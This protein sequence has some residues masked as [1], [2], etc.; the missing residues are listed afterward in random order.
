MSY[1]FRIQSILKV[2]DKSE[3]LTFTNLVKIMFPWITD[4]ETKGI[5]ETMVKEDLLTP[6][7]DFHGKYRITE[8]G[9]IIIQTGGWVVHQHR[10][11]PLPDLQL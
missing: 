4:D 2:Y 10:S 7:D 6:V 3:P 8:R 11:N 5:L 1:N 9:R